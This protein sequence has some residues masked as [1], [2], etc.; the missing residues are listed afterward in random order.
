M[1]AGINTAS[2]IIVASAVLA[3]TCAWSGEYSGPGVT[4][5]EIVIGNTA[6]YSGPVSA[7]GTT[8][9]AAAQCATPWSTPIVQRKLRGCSSE[10]LRARPSTKAMARAAAPI[11]H[12][13]AGPLS[14]KCPVVPTSTNSAP[15]SAA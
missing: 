9:K 6:P 15:A 10:N 8:I 2:R 7:L 11:D 4:K 1:V 3:S 5:D 13:L 12:S 14:A